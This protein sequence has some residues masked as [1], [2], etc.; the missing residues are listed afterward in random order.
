[1]PA[2]QECGVEVTFE[3]AR[4]ACED[5]QF[6]IGQNL[7][8]PAVHRFFSSCY[9]EDDGAKDHIDTRLAECRRAEAAGQEARA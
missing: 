5:P 1:M 8:W 6:A 3:E 9:H 7:V 2:Q 4:M